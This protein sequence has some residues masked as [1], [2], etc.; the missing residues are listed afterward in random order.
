MIT[1]NLLYAGEVERKMTIN[2][3]KNLAKRHT[4]IV[5]VSNSVRQSV[6]VCE[7]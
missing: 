6:G 1:S 5:R 2:C 4:P 3:A 7:Y